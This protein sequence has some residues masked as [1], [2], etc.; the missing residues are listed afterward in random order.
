MSFVYFIVD[1]LLVFETRSHSVVQAALGFA[2]IL[3]PQSPECWLYSHNPFYRA[4]FLVSKTLFSSCLGYR[5]FMP[6]L[7][8]SF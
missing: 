7:F 6:I 4:S 5:L 3:Q 8:S 1:C 2:E